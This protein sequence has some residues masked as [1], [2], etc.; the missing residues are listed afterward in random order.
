M[1][2]GVLCFHCIKQLDW[3]NVVSLWALRSL[4]CFELNFLI[5]LKTPKTF[6]INVRMMDKNILTAIIGGNKPVTLTIV[7]PF[8]S[9]SGHANSLMRGSFKHEKNLIKLPSL[10][11]WKVPEG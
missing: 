2:T 10:P 6:N 8:N 5:F 1:V 11:H 3:A 9:T 4:G 7:K